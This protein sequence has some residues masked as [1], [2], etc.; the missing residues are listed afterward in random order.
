ML[1]RTKSHVA[2]GKIRPIEEKNEL[3]GEFNLR[4]YIF[5]C[6]YMAYNIMDLEVHY[7]ICLHGLGL[8]HLNKG[9]AVFYHVI[10]NKKH[11]CHRRSKYN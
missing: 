5:I 4:L 7:P 10:Y 3:I 8:K 1:S 9:S 6:L 11:R 2:A